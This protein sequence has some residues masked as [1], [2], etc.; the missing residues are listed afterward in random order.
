MIN[1]NATIELQTND[2]STGMK[3]TIS[4]TLDI[5]MASRELKDSEKAELKDSAIA[6][7]GIAV[8]VNSKNTLTNVTTEQVT[9]I[10]TGKST[11][12]SQI[13]K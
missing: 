7:D 9:E 10:F 13:I 4:G 5:G 8:I 12:W 6:L 1:K 3:D 11:K 2:S